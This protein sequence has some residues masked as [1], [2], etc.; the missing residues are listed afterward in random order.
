VNEAGDDD[1]GVTLIPHTHA[2]RTFGERSV[3]DAVN[4]EVDLIAR[5][6]ERLAG[7]APA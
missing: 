4:I 7:H 5:Y 2:A 3:G 1:F 6:A